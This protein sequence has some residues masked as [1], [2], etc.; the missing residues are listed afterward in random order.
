MARRPADDRLFGQLFGR[1]LL[2]Y[3][4]SVI[5]ILVASAL[6]NLL[7]FAGSLYMMLVYDSVLPSRSIP[8]L[9]GL[10]A[11]LAL[12]YLIQA[13]LEAVRSDAL[14][15]L[16]DGVHADLFDAVHHSATSRTLIT[17]RESEGLQLTRDLDQVHGFLASNGPL[18]IIDLPW[19]IVFLVV[20][21]A[22]HWAL[23]LTAL[24]GTVV[25]A[26]LAWWT[27][28]R[29]QIV[30][31]ELAEFSGRRF[32]A[33]QTELRFAEASLAMGMQERLLARSRRWDESSRALQGSLS[34][35]IARLGGAGRLFR[36]F[37]QSTM[38][39]VGAL[40]VID[41]K[42]SGGII[43][44]A[45]ILSGR[46]LAPVD[47]AIAT[48]R[49]L[50]AARAGWWRIVEAIRTHPRHAANPVALPAPTHKVQV[51]DLWVIPPGAQA[52][53]LAGVS[54]T[55][56]P[57]QA[58][59][60]IGP[61]AA[62]KS[63]LARALLGIWPPARGE[64]RLDGATH[65]QWDRAQLGAS[66]GYL[67]QAIE[68]LE[69]TVAENIARFEP[70][71]ASQAILAAAGAAGMHEAI[72]ALPHGYDTVI[73]S[74]G[75]ELS[76]GQRQRIALARALYGDPFLVVLDEPNS[77]LDAAGDAALGE[78]ILR[79]RRRGGIVV[80]V[81]H[82]P[83]TLGPVSHVAVLSAGRLVDYGERDEV[84]KRTSK[85]ELAGTPQAQA[86]ARAD[87][88]ARAQGALP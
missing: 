16:A 9:S 87:P 31:R 45:S 74:G 21:T 68:L 57:G 4:P 54:L 29:S 78:A 60:I 46:A 67:P 81:T 42:A 50:A 5:V 3:R 85:I 69:G 55:L 84:L 65:D 24:L 75:G 22:L 49:N 76:A 37:L 63:T 36:L 41:G 83:A 80:M 6:V 39:T 58:L 34:R 72:L 53:A 7:V 62:G 82:R 43:L 79:V 25:L 66:M 40:L 11:M 48:S 17:Q 20:L 88:A 70:N 15:A 12:I 28:R 1:F 52:P 61:S 35:T 56:E 32:A 27:N 38:L 8:T 51:R 77:N 23:G 13:A 71:A 73:G 14:L 59:A 18:A 10:F 19:V 64:I 33:N 44:A 86:E 2:R 30:T 26:A 47:Q